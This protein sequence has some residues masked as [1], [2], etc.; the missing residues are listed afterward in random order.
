MK[1]YINLLPNDA[2]PTL[3]LKWIVFLCSMWML[4]LIIIAG[5]MWIYS[6]YLSGSIEKYQAKIAQ[7]KQAPLTQADE[8]VSQLTTQRDQLKKSILV[9]KQTK[10]V[11]AKQKQTSYSSLLAATAKAYVPGCWIKGIQAGVQPDEFLLKG[12]A[13][14]AQLIM[15]MIAKLKNQPELAHL[16]LKLFSIKQL[17]NGEFDFLIE[18]LSP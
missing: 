4:L 16:Q 17:E 8:V 10:S 5:G 3:S 7:Q 2:E 12:S 6:L 13:Q 18:G 15:E 9:A 1:Q 14:S 11:L